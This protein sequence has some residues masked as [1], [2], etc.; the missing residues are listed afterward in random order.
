MNKS[1]DNTPNHVA[2]IMDGNGRWAKLKGKNRLFGHK[3]GIKSVQKIVEYAKKIEIK[4]LTLYA[5]S[6]EN[7]NRPKKE[8]ETLMNILIDTLKKEI[9]KM[10]ENN[11]R[12]KCIG[13]I[14]KL[15]DNVVKEL[16]ETIKKTSKN[17]GLVLTLALNYG[18]KKELIYAIKN[19]ATKVK[20]NLISI[21]NIDEKIINNH[22]YSGDLPSVDLLIRT[23]GE[24]RISNFLLW[25]ISYAEL[26]FSEVFWPDFDEN[27]FE[28]AIKNYK[29]RERR[30]GKT[31]DQIKN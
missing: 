20:K 2:I 1:L 18:F 12:F 29:K 3:N 24:Q 7:W 28:K 4:N 19:L 11:V 6:T 27:H 17:D 5:F 14:S 15:P 25:Q 16:E 31:S 22:L 21:E 26:F 9:N 13:D 30:F 10:V 23:S 8:I